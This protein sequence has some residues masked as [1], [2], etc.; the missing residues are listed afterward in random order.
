[1]FNAGSPASVADRASKIDDDLLEIERLAA[2][3][4]QAIALS[5]PGREPLRYARLSSHL[6][7]SA[8]AFRQHRI[9]P[10]GTVALAVS[11]GPAFVTAALAVAR[12]SACAPLDLALTAEEC[13]FHLARID[14]AALVV[15]EG[16]SSPVSAVARELGMRLIRIRSTPDAP[17][18]IFQVAGVESPNSDRPGRRTG[19]AFLLHTSATTDVPK[20]VPW[21][22]AIVRAALAQDVRAFELTAQDR[23]LSLVPASSSHGLYAVLTQ[24]SCG[25]SAFCPPSIDASNLLAYLEAF[26]PTWFSGGPTVLRM[27]LAQA[28]EN[29]EFFRRLPLRF[30]RSV[31]AP[32]GEELLSA[33][34]SLLGAPMLDS[35]GLTE[36][37]GVTRNTPSMRKPGSVGRSVSAELAIHDEAGRFWSCG[38]V[39]EV[40]ARGPT[41][42]SGYLDNPE[43]NREAFR[44][45]WFRTGDM[46]HLDSDGFLFLAG[47]V[48]EIVNKG[49][50]KI[51]PQEVDNV[52]ATHPALAEV[53]AFAIP[54]RTLGEDIAAAAVLRPGV[55]LSELELRRFASERLAAYKIPRHVVFVDSIPRGAMGKPKRDLLA[56][57]FQ[58]LG[59]PGTAGVTPPSTEVERQ[60]AGIW[61]RTLGVECI[62]IDD[63]FFD[64]GGD[65][66]SAALM[67]AHV[68]ERLKSGGCIEALDF[69]DQPTIACLA[70]ILERSAAQTES[71]GDAPV[72]ILMMNK[73]GGRVPFFCF[74]SSEI[75]P[76]DYRHLARS[77]SPDQPLATVCPAPAVEGGR[78]LRLEEVARRSLVTIRAVQKNGPYFLGG[79]CYGGLVAFESCRQLVAA[80][81][82]V[83]LLA[84][85]DTDA[86]GYPKV[87]RH[88]RRYVQEAGRMLR[89][90]IQGQK[91]IALRDI[92]RHVAALTRIAWLKIRPAGRRAAVSLTPRYRPGVETAHL[93][94]SEYVP[95][96]LNVPIVHF[97][98]T[99][100]PVSARIL[101]DPR[102]GWRDFA[103]RGFEV[104]TV[105]GDHNSLCTEVNA[106]SLA[107]ELEKFLASGR[108]SD[109]SLAETAISGR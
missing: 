77:L 105:P 107:A 64:L 26:C 39:G 70:R 1:V 75:G 69:F 16:L 87:S 106:P 68:E 91:P 8:E 108:A 81:E 72:R 66:L 11:N 56:K 34:E 76:Y 13:R 5:A 12:G 23:F 103:G 9:L 3:A 7:A 45:R 4:P 30:V 101:D 32:S 109:C 52:L 96:T 46:G 74:S 54:H 29:P 22:H 90:A 25:G 37:P 24:L 44:E 65:S 50:S 41:L 6:T 27:I 97:I 60:L 53:A 79:Y 38:S 67:L 104:R 35:Y 59:A 48:K 89:A 40:V 51:V 86:P 93:L 62:G 98:G 57:Q 15:E 82:Q 19:A 83:A 28:R 31:G 99:G 20:L 14:A 71:S 78:L 94:M 73:E 17:A 47:R 95:R 92:A 21:S 84:L 55:Q 33:L 10:G 80:G 43:A 61:R 36:I 102:L 88:W 100:T 18:G 49:G 85:L 42:M 2:R 58:D 63:N